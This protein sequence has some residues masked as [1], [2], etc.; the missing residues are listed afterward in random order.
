MSTTKAVAVS[1]YGKE[2]E[3]RE[4]QF[5]DAGFGFSF[6]TVKLRVSFSMVTEFLLR[7][8]GVDREELVG[9]SRD[10]FLSRVLTF[11]YV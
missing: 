4:Y 8:G 10:F 2:R 3:R 7:V 1:V 6:L 5:E 9:I 11:R